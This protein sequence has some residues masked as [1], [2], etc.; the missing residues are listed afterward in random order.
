[1]VSLTSS[2][3][4]PKYSNHAAK[5]FPLAGSIPA[6]NLLGWRQLN[7]AIAPRFQEWIF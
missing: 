5:N 1:L 3:V 6:D 7:E 2:T 4:I